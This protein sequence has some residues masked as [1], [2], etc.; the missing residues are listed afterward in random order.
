MV[1]NAWCCYEETTGKTSH[2]NTKNF[3]TMTDPS[4]SMMC[5]AA[6]YRAL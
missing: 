1:A 6:L 4:G 3:L 2:I 5:D